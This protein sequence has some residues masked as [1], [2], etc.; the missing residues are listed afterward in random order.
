MDRFGFLEF[1]VLDR[2]FFYVAGSE[3][4]ALLRI[5]SSPSSSTF[6]P[7]VSSTSSVAH[8]SWKF[9]ESFRV[10]IDERWWMNRMEPNKTIHLFRYEKDNNLLSPV[11]S[12]TWT[13]ANFKDFISLFLDK[14]K[15]NQFIKKMLTHSLVWL[16]IVADISSGDSDLWSLH[17]SSSVLVPRFW[18]ST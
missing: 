12:H 16:N 13:P 10:I 6:E 1:L 3:L 8:F 17:C 2:K 7:V 9:I 15:K 11:Y 5:F 4:V 18:R 14:R